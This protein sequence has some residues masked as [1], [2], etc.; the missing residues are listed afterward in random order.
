[1]SALT[2]LVGLAAATGC[3]ATT[4]PVSTNNPKSTLTG[5]GQGKGG[6]S[7]NEIACSDSTA[8]PLGLHCFQSICLD[9]DCHTA[10]LA[11]DGTITFS[12]DGDG[13]G[14]VTP[15]NSTCSGANCNCLIAPPLPPGAEP[16]SYSTGTP[17]P[18]DVCQICNPTLS[19][20]AWSNAANGTAC[21]LDPPNPCLLN[22]ACLNG[23]CVGSG[24]A[25]TGTPCVNPDP[26]CG[27]SACS[28]GSCVSNCLVMSPNAI[29]FGVTAQAPLPSMAWCP[30]IPKTISLTNACSTPLTINTLNNGGDAAFVIS[31]APSAPFTIP[32]GNTPVTFQVTFEPSG[33]GTNT[34]AISAQTAGCPDTYTTDL[35]AK[36]EMGAADNTDSFTVTLVQTPV[37]LL[38]VLDIDDCSGTVGAI[39]DNY[40]AI[41]SSVMGPMFLQA[42][43]DN[44]NFNMA[45]TTDVPDQG[46]WFDPCPAPICEIN[47]NPLDGTFNR[48]FNN[49]T[50]NGALEL[51]NLFPHYASEAGDPG[52][53]ADGWTDEHMWDGFYRALCNPA[54]NGATCPLNALAGP[55][56]GF[57]RPGAFLA[58]INFEDDNEDDHS[59]LL[60]ANDPAAYW[61]FL[62]GVTGNPALT[63]Y[64]YLADGSTSASTNCTALVELS[65]P[66][67]GGNCGAGGCSLAQGCGCAAGTVGTGAGGVLENM[68]ANP[69]WPSAVVALWADITAEGQKLF[70]LTEEPGGQI[71]VTVQGTVVCQCGAPPC[72]VQ[73][74]TSVPPCGAAAAWTYNTV[75]NSIDFA[76]VQNPGN[77]VTVTYPA[78]CP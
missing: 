45:L 47:S 18:A 60:G 34:G 59:S 4:A 5:P 3:P 66:A 56:A 6:S 15:C 58:I 48:V 8:C 42:E 51:A 64:S 13:G 1:M 55:N 57:R 31:G 43:A 65:Q 72:G 20:T 70:P 49:A 75:T 44:I 10:C 36:A 7:C 77:N 37:D 26:L 39:G 54:I 23:V 32:A 41:A 19:T 78:A 14:L 50:P 74:P 12:D 71:N 62:V 53:P 46:G 25:G 24:N 40:G 76:A 16:T 29:D 2:L 27:G 21:E 30:S 33:A 67:G 17:N 61:D 28:N 9:A 63:S 69:A 68:N 52:S 22:Q 35:T 73:T 38:W 11:T